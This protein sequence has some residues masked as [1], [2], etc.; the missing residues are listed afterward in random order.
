LD[1]A[2]ELRTQTRLLHAQVEGTPFMTRLLAGRTQRAGYCLMLRNLHP[3]YQSL[4]SVAQGLAVPPALAP[5]FADELLRLPALEADLAFLHGQ[6]WRHELAVLPAAEAYGR[7]L[8]ALA[9]AQQSLLAAHAYVRYLGDLAGG[10][11]LRGIVARSLQ[12][13]GADG[14]AFYAF[15]APDDVQRL[16]QAF[17]S[18]LNRCAGSQ[19][20]AA[21]IVAEAQRAF[22]MHHRLFTE[23]EAA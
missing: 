2:G 10:Q 1:L 14:T 12:L 22:R 8:D 6:H 3:I 13:P 4:E 17:R 9:P 7:H 5:L 18:G 11:Q 20:E 21:A 23:L 15:G 16:T 19:A